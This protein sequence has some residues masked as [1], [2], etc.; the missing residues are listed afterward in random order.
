[1]RWTL[2]EVQSYIDNQVEES[3]NL[4]YKA[5]DAL[6][7]TDGKKKEVSKDV[8]AMANAAGGVI[9]YGLKEY[10]DQTKKHLAEKIDPLNRQVI[11]KEWLEQVINSNIQ[12]KIEGIIITPVTVNEAAGSVVYIVEVPQSNTAHQAADKKYYKRY[13][14]ESVAME[15]Y[16]IRDIMSRL[17]HPVISLKLTVQKKIV[18]EGGGNNYF[19]IIDT[20]PTKE[21]LRNY[22]KISLLNEGRV[23]ANFVNYYLEVAEEILHEKEDS[24]SRSKNRPGYK[25]FYGENTFRDVVDVTMGFPGQHIKK[26]GPSRYEPILPGTQSRTETIKLKD[27]LVD[28]VDTMLYWKVFADNAEVRHGSISLSTLINDAVWAES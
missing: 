22:L 7:K 26:Y 12:P 23:Y 6:Q 27:R 21:T 16:E 10:G 24:L 20:T 5:A 8:S 19:H 2:T 11:S 17:K 1:M 3:I 13:N 28:A 15:D 4:D 18:K 14:F 9:V 25:I